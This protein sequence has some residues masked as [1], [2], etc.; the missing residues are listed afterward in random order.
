MRKLA[1]HYLPQFIPESELAGS[2]VVVV[3]LLRASSTICQALAAGARCVVPCLEIDETLAK[4]QSYSRD[5][6]VLGGERGGRQIEGFDLGNSPGEY[7][8]DRLYGRRVLFTTTNGT[9]ALSHARL[10][11]RVM[12]GAAV[13]RQALVEAIAAE[14]RIDI[15]CAG[16]NGQVTREDLLAA[17][18]ICDALLSLDA[19]EHWETN[20]WA[21]AVLAEW[22]ELKTL[23]GSVGNHVSE[24]LALELRSTPGGKNLLALDYDSDLV[25]CSQLDTLDVVPELDPATGELRLR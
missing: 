2:T 8:A 10:A 4:A 24:Q 16:T 22:Q 1:V 25:L 13:N 20:E 11:S 15:L 6:I 12:I 9:K 23:A 5:E 18:A 7:S 14:A 21:Q 19:V 17:G 3:D